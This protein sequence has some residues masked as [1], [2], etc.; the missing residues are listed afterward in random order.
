MVAFGQCAND[1][2]SMVEALLSDLDCRDKSMKCHRLQHSFEHCAAADRDTL[3]ADFSGDSGS[4]V[5]V[6]AASGQNADQ[7]DR[8]AGANGRTDWFTSPAK[9]TIRSTPS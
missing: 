5:E 4:K 1:L 9:S 2:A 8:P 3:Q 6:C 7:Y